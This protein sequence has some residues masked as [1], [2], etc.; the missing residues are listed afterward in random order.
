MVTFGFSVIAETLSSQ[1]DSFTNGINGFAPATLV[2]KGFPFY[3][4]V[5][6]FTVTSIAVMYFIMNK[7]DWISVSAPYTA[8]KPKQ[9]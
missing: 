6:S 8:T 3:I 7:S 4:L 2:P 1:F 5:I 9:K